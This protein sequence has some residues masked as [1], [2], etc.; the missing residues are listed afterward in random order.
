MA[1]RVCVKNGD[2]I[3][4]N[5]IIDLSFEDKKTNIKLDYKEDEGF[6]LSIYNKSQKIMRYYDIINGELHCTSME[7]VETGAEILEA[8]VLERKQMF[9][10]D[11][12]DRIFDLITANFTD[13]RFIVQENY[14][15]IEMNM[16]AVDVQSLS[17]MVE[18]E[19]E[20]D[21]EFSETMKWETASDVVTYIETALEDALHDIED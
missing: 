1:N 7:D 4:F 18:A 11:I 5:A 6:S 9:R 20:I 8:E 19:F 3:L 13:S 21:I 10:D 14:T 16:D 15:W 12:R 17:D 2:K